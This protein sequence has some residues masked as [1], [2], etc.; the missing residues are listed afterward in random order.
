MAPTH[1]LHTVEET[2]VSMGKAVLCPRRKFRPESLSQRRIRL[3]PLY[4]QRAYSTAAGAEPCER[5]R[6]KIQVIYRCVGGCLVLQFIAIYSSRYKF[7]IS[8]IPTRRLARS[9][10]TRNY[11]AYSQPY[12]EL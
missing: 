2:H 11:R 3:A 5:W 12:W 9:R 6:C 10:P 1:R 7:S 8:V 4:K